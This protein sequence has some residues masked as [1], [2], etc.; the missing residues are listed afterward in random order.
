MCCKRKIAGV[1]MHNERFGQ[2]SCWKQNVDY[3]LGK[4]TLWSASITSFLVV[5][6]FD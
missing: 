5:S 6:T 3:V 1:C 2:K 4:K